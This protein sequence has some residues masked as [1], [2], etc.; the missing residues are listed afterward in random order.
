MDDVQPAQVGVGARDLSPWRLAA[1]RLRPL[2]PVVGV[3]SVGLLPF[4]TCLA[5]IA[6]HQ[7]CPACG[8]TRAT[9]RLLHG[10]LGGATRFQP[11][12]VPLAVLA[13][14]VVLSSPWLS[15]ARWRW[16]VARSSA[17]AGVA[18]VAVWLARFGGMFG[19]PV[20]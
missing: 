3:C 4:R 5:Q 19:G 10:D 2:L 7:P 15:E 12:A 11:L 16:L 14:G 6:F 8:L 18:L 13:A 17:V 9:L 1:V 20:P